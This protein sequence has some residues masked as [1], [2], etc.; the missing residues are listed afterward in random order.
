MTDWT[1]SA[2]LGKNPE[3]W[4]PDRNSAGEESARR[5][6]YGCPIKT[7]C[8][9]DAIGQGEEY[10]IRAGIWIGKDTNWRTNLHKMAG[11]PLAMKWQGMCVKGL[12]DLTVPDAY[13]VY[14]SGHRKCAGCNPPRKQAA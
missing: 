1:A 4:F 14:P 13:R 11:I 7:Q 10:G 5:T 3:D 9:Q 2:C 8:A 12:H 6:C